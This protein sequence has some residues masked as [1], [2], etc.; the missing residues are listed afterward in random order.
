MDFILV[1]GFVTWLI[2]GL[3]A[4]SISENKGNSGCAGFCLGFLLGPLGVLVAAVMSPNQHYIDSQRKAVLANQLQTGTLKK[5]PFCAELIQPEAVVCR[6]CGRDI[7]APNQVASLTAK[8]TRPKPLDSVT[9]EDSCPKCGAPNPAGS[10][11]C[12][13]CGTALV[14]AAERVKPACSKCGF[15][16]PAE[17]K[18]CGKCGTPLGSNEPLQKEGA[19]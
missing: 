10:R 5:C 11:F 7:G 12:T 15:A 2:C 13:K 9:E 3:I 14:L 18:F 19:R 1:V 16:N 8:E 4:M 6:Y 17:S